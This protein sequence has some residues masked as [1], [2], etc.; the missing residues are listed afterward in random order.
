M[1][2]FN[3]KLTPR[4]GVKAQVEDRTPKLTATITDKTGGPKATI[5]PV[6]GFTGAFQR[7]GKFF[8]A[9]ARPLSI[10][11]RFLSYRRGV[12][13]SHSAEANAAPT[14]E[15]YADNDVAA[16]VNAQAATV[17]VQ[18]ASVNQKERVRVFARGVAYARAAAAYIRGI[19]LGLR[20]AAEAAPGSAAQYRAGVKMAKTAKATHASGVI[21]ESRK[22][23]IP[24]AAVAGGQFVAAAVGNPNMELPDLELSASAVAAYPVAAVADLQINL[25]LSA[26]AAWWFY[27]EQD[28]DALHFVQAFSGMQTG[29]TLEID[30]EEE[31]R[32]YA[33]AYA[34]GAA[35]ILSS[36]ETATMTNNT[37]EVA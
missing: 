16:Q 20:A 30:M 3:G 10:L 5:A 11:Y 23:K 1:S 32:F 18:Q 24:T 22:N 2:I 33:N 4:G 7:A 28:G 14:V 35:P 12:A 6:G 8:T 34:D 9:A 29:D 26:K 13:V 37:L 19:A 31:S 36:A 17:P 15:G 25:V 21:A 27:P